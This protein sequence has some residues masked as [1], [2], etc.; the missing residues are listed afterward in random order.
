MRRLG[1]CIAVLLSIAAL[2]C[3]GKSEVKSVDVAGTISLDGK[4]LSGVEV[5]F[6]SEKFEG[7]GKTD[8]KG[9]YRLVNG[10]VPGANKVFLKKFDTAAAGGI[11]KSIKGMDDMQAAA[12]MEAQGKAKGAKSG[13]LIP[14]DYSDPKT[15][16]LTFNVPEGGS[17]AADFRISSGG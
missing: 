15:T 6:S 4:P 13:S 10:A 17:E 12:M 7:Y 9:K 16:K 2:G 11:D 1:G 8:E 5:Y 14:P 3:G